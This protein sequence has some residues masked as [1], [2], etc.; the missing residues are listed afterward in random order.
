MNTAQLQLDAQNVGIGT[1]HMI[2]IGAQTFNIIGIGTD[3]LIEPSSTS[4]NTVFTIGHSVS[5]SYENFNTIR[6]L[7]H[8]AANRIDRLSGRD[9]HHGARTIRELELY[10]HRIEHH[11]VPG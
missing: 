10:L 1:R 5:G 2:Q 9:R 3:P 4:G 6:C 7:R 11:A 8:A